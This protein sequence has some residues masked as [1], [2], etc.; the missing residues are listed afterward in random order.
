MAGGIGGVELSGE[1]WC[2]QVA[3]RHGDTDGKKRKFLE[4]FAAGKSVGEACDI[5]GVSKST[6]HFYRR[7]DEAFQAE[8]DDIRLNRNRREEGSGEGGPEPV[9]D[10]PEFCEKF[11]HQ[12]LAEHHLRWWDMMNGREPRNLHESMQYEVG[13]NPNYF[14]FLVPVDHAK[15]TV[16]TMNWVTWRIYRNWNERILIVSKT[17]TLAKKFLL[18]IK[19]RLTSRTYRE[20]I[21]R[22]GPEGGFKSDRLPWN[23]D[24]IYING[25]DDVD[26]LDPNEVGQKDPTVQALGIKGHIYGARASALVLDDAIDTTNVGQVDA[27]M[28]WLTGM[29]LTRPRP[30]DPVVVVGTRIASNDLYK[31]LLGQITPTR[32]GDKP[33]WNFLAQPAILEE[34]DPADPDTWKVLWPERN[35]GWMLQRLRNAQSSPM[36]F[37]LIWQ[38]RDTGA[39]MAFPLGAVE[40]SINKFRTPGLLNPANP[41]SRQGGMN[42][43]YVC[44]GLDPATTGNTAMVVGAVDA[45]AKKVWLLDAKNIPG[46]QIDTMRETMK[47]LT[48][49]YGIREWV[50]ERNAFQRSIVQDPQLSVDINA[51]GC[52]LRE[53]YTAG[54][55]WDE[56]F[57]VLS[58]SGLFR[59]CADFDP[60][61]GR[62]T[63]RT[64]GGQID[65]PDNRK[66]AWVGQMRDQ[67]AAFEPG[68]MRQ[69]QKTDLVM[70]LW[71]M[72]I[73][74]RDKFGFGRTGA[75]PF[76]KPS[77]FAS[78]RQIDSRHVVNLDELEQQALSGDDQDVTVPRGGFFDSIR[79]RALSRG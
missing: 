75:L 9:P 58:M 55:K 68:N 33:T 27:Q 34:P 37:Q 67:L 66:A 3:F 56:D 78:R 72:M 31:K 17:T 60:I 16:I 43:V 52:R 41:A 5:I 40:S 46:M 76:A 1:D 39:D 19:E 21:Q 25:R 48:E 49:Q 14:L 57:G 10:F 18:A 28:E 23:Q 32:E 74:A 71:F 70:A 6:Y 29:A 51:M 2:S 47:D 69:R 63:R 53:H 20:A 65:L 42:G 62:W 22:F 73:A 26:G 12:P 79:A 35:P 8:L 59:S 24:A 36:R 4:L 30:D 11:L 45:D 15:S 77:S 13:E 38:Q 44:A 54:N 7:N 50:V 61:S 64:G